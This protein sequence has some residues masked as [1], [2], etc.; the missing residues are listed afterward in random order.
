MLRQW[1]ILG[2]SLV[3]FNAQAMTP[4]ELNRCRIMLENAWKA[5]F[6]VEKARIATFEIIQRASPSVQRYFI[7]FPSYEF[8]GPMFA[9]KYDLQ[10]KL[11]HVFRD[12]FKNKT[13]V[14]D[15]RIVDEAERVA[16]QLLETNPFTVPEQ[17]IIDHF[18]KN[19]Q[20]PYLRVRLNDQYGS[21]E[22]IADAEAIVQANRRLP[23]DDIFR[24]IVDAHPRRKSFSQ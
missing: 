2:L 22:Q 4:E 10:V 9:K 19:N 7:D 11:Q 17:R 3:C 6:S 8:E 16:K 15:E 20:L 12:E 1:K 5:S 18:R 23:A 13:G 21:S 24:M 14:T